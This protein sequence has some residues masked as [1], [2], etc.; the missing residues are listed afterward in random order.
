MNKTENMDRLEALRAQANAMED[1][2]ALVGHDAPP[3]RRNVEDALAALRTFRDALYKA[4]DALDG[5]N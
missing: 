3:I 5:V 2:L 1:A 4:E